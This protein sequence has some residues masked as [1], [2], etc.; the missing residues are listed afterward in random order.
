VLE[1]RPALE[2]PVR[3]ELPAVEDGIE[4]AHHVSGH[5]AFTSSS[6][7]REPSEP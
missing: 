2:A 6:P 3:H 1:D 5:A 7:W 4:L